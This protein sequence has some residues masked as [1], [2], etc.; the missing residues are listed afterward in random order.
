[1]DTHIQTPA[2]QPNEEII[3]P[4][5]CSDGV[6]EVLQRADHRASKNIPDEVE[7]QMPA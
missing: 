3:P 5:L 1:V 7:M 4:A 2:R 6:N